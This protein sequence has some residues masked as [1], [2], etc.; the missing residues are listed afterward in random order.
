MLINELPDDCLLTIFDYVNYLDDLVNCF[1]V[2]GKWSH[3]IAQRTKK[4]KYLLDL[5]PE[6]DDCVYYRDIKQ[7]DGTDLSTEFPNLIISYKLEQEEKRKHNFALARNQEPSQ[8]SINSHHGLIEKYRF[9]LKK[10]SCDLFEPNIQHES[11]SVKQLFRVESLDRFKKDAHLF[12]NLERINVFNCCGRDSM[13]DGPVLEKLK[14]AE[15]AF[16]TTLFL[17]NEASYAFQFMDSCPNLQSAHFITN[18]SHLFFDGTLKHESLQDLVISAEIA[19]T[20]SSIFNPRSIDWNDLKRLLMKYPNLKHLALWRQSNITDEHIEELVHILPNLVL[21]DVCGCL[22]V[23]C[24]AAK[25]V[26]DYCKRYGRTIKFYFN[27]NYNEIDSDWPLLSSKQEIISQ[28]LDFMKHCFLK[29][30][31]DLPYFLI[32]IDD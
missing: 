18:S 9:Q 25:Y 12:P 26:Q 2:C 22:S 8:G 6:Y 7:I 32:P 13:Y 31:L 17:G 20:I 24:K 3:L 1:K 5:Y 29:D 11:S 16:M 27:G 19:D 4:V 10:V 14:I 15:F 23:S 28:G 30:F 21:L